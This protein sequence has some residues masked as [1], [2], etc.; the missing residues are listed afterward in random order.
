VAADDG[1]ITERHAAVE[2][3]RIDPLYLRD[4]AYRVPDRLEARVALHRGFSTSPTPWQRWVFDRLGLRFGARVLEIGCG[5]GDLWSE[6]IDR[7]DPSWRLTLAD[8]SERMVDPACPRL[9]RHAR[10]VVA[11]AR[12]LPFADGAF[13]VVV[14][15]HVLYHV[16]ELPRALDEIVRVLVPQ[17]RLVAT[18]VG[19]GHL[20]ELR[21]LLGD[22]APWSRNSERFGLETGP[23]K[24]APWFERVVRSDYEDAFRVTEVEPLLDYLL[25]T[26]IARSLGAADVEE[27]RGE[28]ERRIERDG[29]FAIRKEVGLLDAV[30]TLGA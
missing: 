21:E 2:A 26:T 29:A 20:A 23:A 25:S 30:A 18:T 14:A 17:G 6:N 27:L 13:D 10:F 7:L 4:E 5:P 8:L 1:G 11:D 12:D 22:R 9:G 28:L 19:D 24:L 16:P 15:N 3:L